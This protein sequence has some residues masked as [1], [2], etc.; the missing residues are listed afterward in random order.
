MSAART[1]PGPS[2]VAAECWTCQAGSVFERFTDSARRVLVLAQEEVRHLNHHFIGT[3]H[4]L[5]GLVHA[6]GGMASQVLTGLGVRLPTARQRVEEILQQRGRNLQRFDGHTP[7]GE[8]RCV[9][10]AQCQHRF[11]GGHAVNLRSPTPQH[12]RVGTNQTNPAMICGREP[13]APTSSW[14]RT[15]RPSVPWSSRLLSQEGFGWCGWM[16]LLLTPN[17]GQSWPMPSLVISPPT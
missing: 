12:C 17:V 1:A 6:D 5:L 13:N 9:V 14:L 15:L 3:E 4:L 7:E 2:A 8:V 16:A 10:G 11:R